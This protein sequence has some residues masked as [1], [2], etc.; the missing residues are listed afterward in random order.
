MREYRMHGLE[1]DVIE[2]N[3]PNDRS[4]PIRDVGHYFY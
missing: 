2:R 1:D 3:I 4:K